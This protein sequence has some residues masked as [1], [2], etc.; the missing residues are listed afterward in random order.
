MRRPVP[1][2]ARVLVVLAI[3]CAAPAMGWLVFS[4]GTVIDGP[5]MLG[6]LM[7]AAPQ[8]ARAADDFRTA[9]LVNGWGLLGIGGIGFIFGLFVLMPAGI[10]L[11][12]AASPTRPRPRRFPVLVGGVVSAVTL[13]LAG[14]VLGP[15]WIGPYFQEPDAFLATVHEDSPL[16]GVGLRPTTLRVNATDLGHGATL[17]SLGETGG[18]PGGRLTVVFAP[19]APTADLAVLRQRIAGLPGVSDARLCSP[20]AHNCR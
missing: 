11:L 4:H 3:P 7:T 20:P 18:V 16:L 17:V 19:G 9:C 10:V 13:G 14:W 2:A 1:R 8:F 6:P 15:V 12:A 5:L